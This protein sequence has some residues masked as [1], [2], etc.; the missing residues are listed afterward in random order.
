[1]LSRRPFFAAAALAVAISVAMLAQSDAPAGPRMATAA[2]KFLGSLP[3]ELRA[4]ATY[5]YD[6]PERLS[7]H[8]VPQQDK[9][10]N[11]TRKGVKLQDMTDAQKAAALA[12][13][14]TGLSAKG[15]EQAS[16]IM[17]LEEILADLEKGGTNV[18][19]PNWY[20]V[21]VFGEP[22][23]TGRWGWRVEGHHLSVNLTLDKGVVVGTSPIVFASNPADVKDGP[24]KGTRVLADT[25]DRAA[26]LLA[27]FDE[28][29]RKVVYQAK[30]FAE[31]VAK[32]AAAVG[33]P[34]GLP[35]AKM[36]APQKAA[37][38]KLIEVYA[39]RL[40]AEV[41]AGELKRLRDAGEDQIYFAYCV[42][43]SKPGKPH[44]YRVQGPTFAI[45]FLNVQAD[46]AKNPANHIHSG[47]RKLPKDF[48][49]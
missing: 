19:N 11:P 39:N 36:T 41:A 34:V 43:E 45:E 38:V 14:R 44:S 1:M 24:K 15:F 23:N 20:F 37:L 32:P 10:R 30:Q 7:W 49:L 13:L 17:K 40:P 12:L 26:D 25:E 5:D 22:S 9:D 2:Q 46:S 3:A 29:Q 16:G 8:F 48:G 31:I 47:W 21:T 27:L 18:R 28:E 33:E 35:A 42:E 6:S 4:K